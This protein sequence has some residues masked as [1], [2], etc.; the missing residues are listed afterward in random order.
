MKEH[1][2]VTHNGKDPLLSAEEN[3]SNLVE[4]PTEAEMNAAITGNVK[5]LMTVVGYHIDTKGDIC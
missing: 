3:T 2:W 5:N 1:P 4:P